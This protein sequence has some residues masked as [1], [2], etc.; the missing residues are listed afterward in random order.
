MRQASRFDGSGRIMAKVYGDTVWGMSAQSGLRVQSFDFDLTV[1]EDWLPDEDGDDV[2][3]ALFNEK[4][5]FAMNGFETTGGFSAVLGSSI[6]LANA[7]DPA[8]HI[9]DDVS[10]GI[11]VV[12]GI[13]N[14]R[15]ARAHQMFD[16]SGV[17]KPFAG[18]LQTP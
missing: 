5:T 3:G 9:T 1:D 11:T 6:A 4:A 14:T 7:L 8:D 10:G 15:G 2:A 18:A 16:T 12:T 17:Y 13:K